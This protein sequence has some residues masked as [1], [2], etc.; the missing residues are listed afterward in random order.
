MRN[1][2]IIGL[3]G[4]LAALSIALPMPARVLADVQSPEIEAVWKSQKLRFVYRGYSTFY[5]CGALRQK[6][7]SI[8][9]ELGA[10]DTLK[11][12]GH[13]CDD[14][15]GSARFDILLESPV[16]AT[17][18]H[19]AALT[20]YSPEQRLVARVRGEPLRGA[21]DLERFR[22]SW[23]TIS[24]ASNRSMRLDPGDCELVEQL[25][26]SI[27]PRLSVQIVDNNLRCSPFRSL[28]RPRLTVLALIA[29]PP[30]RGSVTSADV[31]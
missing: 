3:A 19:V 15:S 28:R 22:A 5:T 7:R 8:L 12:S 27:L 1:H 21:P 23:E 25:L 26:R 6:L 18:E 24:F 31:P 14:A 20:Q 2:R 13:A 10:R 9:I 16:A 29:Q 4:L 17:A 11:L 30:D